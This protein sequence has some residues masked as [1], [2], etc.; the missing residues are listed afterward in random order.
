M[1]LSS[2]TLSSTTTRPGILVQIG[3]YRYSSRGDLSWDGYDWGDGGV[4]YD[5]IESDGS[6]R[7]RVSVTLMD[8]STTW[9]ALILAG[10]SDDLDCFVYLIYQDGNGVISAQLVFVGKIASA[11]TSTDGSG[12]MV[13]FEARAD[14]PD[15]AWTPRISWQSDY[16]VRR[17]SQVRINNETFLLE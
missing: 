17:G 16:A 2:A 8:T 14:G 11:E 1:T 12:Q 4:S 15:V 5:A 6:G 7:Q 9:P 3:D 13:R 10:L